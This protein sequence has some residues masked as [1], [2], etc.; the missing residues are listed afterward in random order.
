MSSR[1]RAPPPP[2][3][4]LRAYRGGA[5]PASGAASKNTGGELPGWGCGCLFLI[6]LSFWVGFL[7]D[8]LG[9][10]FWKGLLITFG[11]VVVIL[12]LGWVGEKIGQADRRFYG[13]RRGEGGPPGCPYCGGA[14]CE[15]CSGTG[16][17]I[18][19]D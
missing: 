15:A 7:G 19:S 3:S 4:R 18:F 14:G 10:G 9:V 12:A 13:P 6:G 16:R 2:P 5:G 8:V 1:R 11:V 17:G